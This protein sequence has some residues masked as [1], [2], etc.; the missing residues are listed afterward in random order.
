MIAKQALMLQTS[1]SNGKRIQGNM[2][3]DLNAIRA[4]VAQL[5]GQRQN[6]NIQM[7]KP[8]A[9]EYRVRLLPNKWIKDPG[10]VILER[11][12]YWWTN[13]GILAPYQFN[14]ADPVNDLIKKLYNDKTEGSRALAKNLKAKL[15]CFV[16]LIVRG[17]EDKGV[18]IWSVNRDV[19]KRLLSFF[20][21]EDYGDIMD[22][23]AGYDLKV[24]IAPE[25]GKFFN[26][27]QMFQTTIDPKKQGPAHADIEAAK[28]WADSVPN[29][30]DMYKL[31]TAS[32]I[33]VLLNAYMNA[34]QPQEEQIASGETARGS[35]TADKLDELEAEMKAV[36]PKTEKKQEK[37]EAVVES[38]KKATLDE[39]FDELMEGDE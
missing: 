22:L 12:L 8:E 31:K 36:K 1:I 26:G 27:K 11:Y 30:D 7:W 29:V 14:L 37:K 5:S 16:P 13:P 35:S 20:L 17:H 4:K 25:V 32:E 33:E 6:S 34:D 18:Q 3:I 19:Y 9:G 28:K 38:V 23:T 21:D 39:A 24:V 15:R 10:T 2:A